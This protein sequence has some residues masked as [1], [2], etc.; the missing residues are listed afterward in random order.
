MFFGVK[1][2]KYG[3]I[4]K[5][6]SMFFLNSKMSSKMAAKVAVDTYNCIKSW[7]YKD[8]WMVLCSKVKFLGSRNS[9]MVKSMSSYQWLFKFSRRPP[10]WLPRLPPRNTGCFGAVFSLRL[11]LAISAGF[12][13]Y[14]Q[15][16]TN[17][18]IYI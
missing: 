15:I 16:S 17:R 13:E 18:P 10:R 2:L 1:E 11:Q 4:N 12:S 5:L 6:R 9:N 7:T 14:L 8:R 3:K